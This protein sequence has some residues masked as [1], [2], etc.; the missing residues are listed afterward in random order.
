MPYTIKDLV[1]VL[2]EYYTRANLDITDIHRREIAFERWNDF[3]G[4]SLRPVYFQYI[5]S[6]SNIHMQ[7]YM[8]RQDIIWI[9]TKL[10]WV[11]RLS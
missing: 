1:V 8:P 9:L 3:R 5:D 2:R 11:R 7:E 4:P 6:L 10:I